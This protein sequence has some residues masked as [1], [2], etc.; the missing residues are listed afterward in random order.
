VTPYTQPR[1]SN[2][3]PIFI[4]VLM[5]LLCMFLYAL[6]AQPQQHIQSERRWQQVAKPFQ[7]DKNLKIHA[8]I[9]A[10]IS[11][12]FTKP[13]NSDA[14]TELA[15]EADFAIFEAKSVRFTPQG[16]SLI[17]YLSVQLAKTAGINLQ[18]QIPSDVQDDMSLLQLSA[19]YE[20]LSVGR[21]QKSSLQI[22][23]GDTL[24]VS[25]RLGAHRGS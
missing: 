9:A 18:L 16:L 3:P 22:V 10:L 2:A 21:S 1:K 24:K 23:S 14:N 20:A 15:L 7:A 11:L 12:G 6:S 19:A 8:Q 5:A 25:I 4:G 13:V 17:R